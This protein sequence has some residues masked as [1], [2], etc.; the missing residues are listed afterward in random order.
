[1]LL[2]NE[3]SGKTKK[4]G[5]GTDDGTVSLFRSYIFKSLKNLKFL[6]K[7]PGLPRMTG[8]ILPEEDYWIWI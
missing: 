4:E 3:I 5:N 7:Q 1:M 6:R 2:T 8:T